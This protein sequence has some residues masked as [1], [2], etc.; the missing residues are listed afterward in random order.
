MIYYKVRNFSDLDLCF[1]EPGGARL[2]DVSMPEITRDA[3]GTNYSRYRI[4]PLQPG[5][6]TTIGASLRRILISSLSGAAVTGIRLAEIPDDPNEIKGIEESLIDLVLNVKQLRFRPANE[7]TESRRQ[8]RVAL[9]YPNKQPG[10]ITGENLELPEDLELINPEIAI[11][12]STGKGGFEIELL[13]ETGTGYETAEVRIEVPDDFIPVDAM[14][15][16]VPR[17]NYIVEHTRVGQMTDFDRLLLEVWTDGTIQPDDAVSQ[18][19]KILTQYA[20]AVAGYGRDVA[21]L[22]LDE[23]PGAPEDDTNRSIEDLNLS[24]RTT[25]ALKRANITTIGQVLSLS[26]NDL[27]HL[28]NFGQKSL[29]ELRDALVANGYQLASDLELSGEDEDDTEEDVTEE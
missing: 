5:W 4:E 18:A 11:A 14:Y 2:F 12:T 21:D 22:G 24:M 6:G 29:V 26:D 7:D 27:L 8:F 3:G 20:T 23:L 16:P 28:R 10:D 25:N 13:V 9:K 17:V 15:T 19:A 1:I